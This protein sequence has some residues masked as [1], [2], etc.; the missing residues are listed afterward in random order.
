[1]FIRKKVVSQE[2]RRS[3]AREKTAARS[4]RTRLGLLFAVLGVLGLLL[5]GC[6]TGIGAS[7]GNNDVNAE[8]AQTIDWQ[9]LPAG[10]GR[11]YPAVQVTDA[12]NEETGLQTGD[13]APNFQ[14]VLDDG[15]QLSLRDLEGQPVLINFWA[16][17]CGP[18]RMEMPDL[19]E[20]QEENAEL[21]V[22]AVNVME[23]QDAIQ[24]FVEEFQMSMPVVVDTEGDLRQLYGVRNMPTSIFIDREGR[25]S[26]VW[27][28]FLTPDKLEEFAE[29]IS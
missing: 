26:T 20:L 28:G 15:R 17:W 5:A 24:S 3:H 29:S 23:N 19:V 16:S 8:S 2:D 12:D 22:L 11:G 13:L 1:M 4:G 21:V 7:D 14:L 10:L 9:D 18:C 25:I 27:A 6:G